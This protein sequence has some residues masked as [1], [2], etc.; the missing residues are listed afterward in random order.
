MISL[1]S[2]FNSFDIIWI[3]THGGPSGETTTMIIDTY[4]TA[5][6]SYKYGEGSARAVLVAICLGIFCFFYFRV[7]NRLTATDSK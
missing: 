5:I 4:R 1:I 6:G 2:T 7:I 3:L